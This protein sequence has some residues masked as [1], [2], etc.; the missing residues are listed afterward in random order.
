MLA[1]PGREGLGLRFGKARLG[2]LPAPGVFSRN[3][4]LFWKKSAGTW[5]LVLIHL[6]SFPDSGRLWHHSVQTAGV[7]GP[8]V[9][10]GV[11]P[12]MMEVVNSC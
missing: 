2:V 3:S 9:G 7:E 12:G 4:E 6:Q 1:F 11:K 5:L 10:S 8:E